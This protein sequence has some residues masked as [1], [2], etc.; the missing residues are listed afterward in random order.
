M[1]RGGVFETIAKIEAAAKAGRD[2]TSNRRPSLRKQMI[3]DV[4]CGFYGRFRTPTST[5]L[6]GF[7]TFAK[8]SIGQ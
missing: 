7:E 8:S 4:A 1:E 6:G 5:R 3:V 2:K